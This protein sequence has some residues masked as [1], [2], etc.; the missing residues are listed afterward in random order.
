M[1]GTSPAVGTPRD[2]R[3]GKS[4][5]ES[6]REAAAKFPVPPPRRVKC[7]S[8]SQTGITLPKQRQRTENSK[9]RRLPMPSDDLADSAPGRRTWGDSDDV[10]ELQ[11]QLAAMG[12]ELSLDAVRNRVRL[13]EQRLNSHDK[14]K[15]LR[16]VFPLR[17]PVPRTGGTSERPRTARQSADEAIEQEIGRVKRPSTARA[18]LEHGVAARPAL[19]PVWAE[20]S[21]SDNELVDDEDMSTCLPDIDSIHVDDSTSETASGIMGLSDM[22]PEEG[23]PE[24]SSQGSIVHKPNEDTAHNAQG[25]LT[26]REWE[27]GSLWEW[28]NPNKTSEIESTPRAATTSHGAG[29]GRDEPG[30]V[31]VGAAGYGAWSGEERL[32]VSPAFGLPVQRASHVLTGESASPSVC[33]TARRPPRTA[34]R[35]ATPRSM[36]RSRMGSMSTVVL[37]PRTNLRQSMG[38]WTAPNTPGPGAYNISPRMRKGATFA[39]D[40]KLAPTSTEVCFCC[41]LL[42]LLHCQWLETL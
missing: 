12:I 5:H 35:P 4:L 21:D 13:A 36:P 20:G 32:C 3:S 39:K 22:L 29:A 18:R 25:I 17:L 26:K 41:H 40:R 11:S 42:L 1:V 9:P 31:L 19:S 15:G 14:P 27:H 30:P 37:S 28:G 2:R 7:F 6:G 16:G 34:I 38:M 8:R 10:I 24:D 33:P 23:I